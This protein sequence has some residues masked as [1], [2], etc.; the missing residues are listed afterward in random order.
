[1]VEG[2][3]LGA[4]AAGTISSEF[5]E[6]AE[7]RMAG[8]T[9]LMGAAIASIQAREDLAGSR[10]WI[11]AAAGEERRRVVRDLHDGPQQRLVPHDHH[12][13]AGL[14]GVRARPVIRS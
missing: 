14:P 8:F 5:P 9:E 6:D 10:A 1:M 2:A 4:M 13:Q 12:T 3:L 7:Q 11:V